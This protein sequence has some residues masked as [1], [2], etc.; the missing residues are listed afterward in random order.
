MGGWTI[1]YEIDKSINKCV[2]I[3][4]PHTS[5]W[6]F[7][8]ALPALHFMGIKNLRYLI[9]KEFFFWPLSWLF[10]VT[11]GIAVDRSKKN[12][13]TA[14][15]KSMLQEN[16][17][18]YIL[19]PPEGTRSRVERWKTGFYYTAVDADLPIILGYMDYEKRVL[20]F[21]EILH[22]TGDFNADMALIEAFYRTKSAKHPKNFNPNIFVK[23]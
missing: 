22:P 21:G 4:A 18:L 12:D 9:K 16:D 2:V 11:G 6:D 7:V 3:G 23:K 8:Y 15:L 10:K 13:L 17:S 20:G 19:F 14:L 5:N 1:D